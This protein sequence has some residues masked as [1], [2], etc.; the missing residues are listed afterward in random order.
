[1]PKGSPPAVIDVRQCQEFQGLRLL[2]VGISPR[3]PSADRPPS[4]QNLKKRIRSHFSGRADGSTLRLRAPTPDEPLPPNGVT[5]GGDTMRMLR[6]Y[7]RSMRR[8]M[9]LRTAMQ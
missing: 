5:P 1:M 9:P 7:A 6:M 2:Y 4:R 3:P 8:T